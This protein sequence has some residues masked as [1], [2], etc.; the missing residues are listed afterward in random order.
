MGAGIALVAAQNAN[1]RVIVMDR[2]AKKL[3]DCKKYA[4]KILSKAVEKGTVPAAEK[5]KILSLISTTTSLSDFTPCDFVVEAV[6]ENLELK[7]TLFTELSAITKPDAILASNTSSIS[8]TR[9][10]AATNRADR[11]I[12]MHFMNP[13]PIMKLVEIISGIATS[14][15]TLDTT[16]ALAAKMGKITTKSQDTPGFIANRILM[17]MINEAVFALSEGVGSIEDIDTTMKLGTNVPMG[18]LTLADFIGLDTCL[19]IMRVLHSELG[20]DKYRPC[21]LLVKYV[22]A[23]WLGKKSGKGFYDYSVKK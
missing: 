14:K 3:L 15:T 10:A 21:P 1:L 9:I 20:E 17:P 23:G 11:V 12:G 7:K 18:P 6:S 13:V 5:D 2:D 22:D 8:I 16:L 19:A 4:D